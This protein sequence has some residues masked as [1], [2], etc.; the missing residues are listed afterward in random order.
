MST[1][2]TAFRPRPVARCSRCG[3]T[4]TQ[5]ELINTTC[6]NRGSIGFCRG[7]LRCVLRRSDWIECPNCELEPHPWS[8]CGAC[9]GSG[10]MFRGKLPSPVVGVTAVGTSVR[11]ELLLHVEGLRGLAGRARVLACTVAD[12]ADHRRLLSHAVELDEYALRLEAEALKS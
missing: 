1:P 12:E 7:I 5:A 8:R 2:Q 3:A 11:P 4:T 6:G 9:N 10:W